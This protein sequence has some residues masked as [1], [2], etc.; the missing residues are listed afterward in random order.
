MQIVKLDLER[1]RPRFRVLQS[2]NWTQAE[3]NYAKIIEW[4]EIEFTRSCL[5]TEMVTPSVAEVNE[6]LLQSHTHCF[7]AVLSKRKEVTCIQ[8]EEDLRVPMLDGLKSYIKTTKQLHVFYQTA[9]ILCSELENTLYYT[10]TW[11]IAHGRYL[12][13]QVLFFVLLLIQ[14]RST[15]LL[16]IDLVLIMLCLK[17][18]R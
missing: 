4:S 2:Y 8:F 11:S 12:F 9:L 13:S 7:I 18:Q 16:T 6:Q 15:V 5:W 1:K 10:C 17:L 3:Y 14:I